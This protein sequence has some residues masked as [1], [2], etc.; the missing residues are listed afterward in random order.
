MIEHLRKYTGLIIFVMALIFVGLTFLGSGNRGGMGSGDPT[1]I[2]IDGTSYSY[3]EYQKLGPST[4]KLAQGLGMYTFLMSLGM[5]FSMDEKATNSFVVNRVLLHKA[6]EEFGVHPSDAEVAEAIKGQTAFQGESGTFDQEKYNNI[7]QNNLG[8]LGLAEK[9]L[10]DLVRDDLTMKRLSSIIGDGLTA[11]PEIALEAVTAGDQRLTLQVAR[12]PLS[13]YQ[14]SLKPTDEELK[15][16]WETSKDKYLTE[17]QLKVSYVL[18]TPKYPEPAKD[19]APLPPTATDDEKKAAEVKKATQATADANAKREINKQLAAKVSA[20]LEGINKDA[21]ASF[22]KLAGDSG[23]EVKSTDFFTTTAL[24]PDLNL[25]LRAGD[26]QGSVGAVLNTLTIGGGDEANRYSNAIPI[27]DGQWLVVR[28]EEIKEP[29][30]MEFEEAKEAVRTDYIAKHAAE[31]LKKDADEKTAKIRESLAAGKSFADVAKE[32]ELE[33]KQ[34]GPFG[35]NDRNAA[36][37]D[38]GILF[39]PAATVDQGT[40]ADPVMR[41]DA[42]LLVF[43]EKREIY[44]DNDRA[45]KVDGAVKTISEHQAT[46]AFTS[47]MQNRLESIKIQEPNRK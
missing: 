29:R 46:F 10:F 12:L 30:T 25:Q 14:E 7:V 22:E 31:A 36:D 13:K 34:H 43:V 38:A 27:T 5:D 39:Q 15:T 26:T 35:V 3:S 16:E 17:K 21:N 9:D 6:A 8:R 42:A 40:L 2:T 41:P 32:M 28:A 23:L 20:L 33:I 37:P 47:W 19:E 45:S 4:L 24:P 1:R 11:N 18:A 44:K